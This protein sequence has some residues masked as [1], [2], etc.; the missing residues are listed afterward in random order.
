M[1]NAAVALLPLASTALT[2]NTEAP[3]VVGVPEI[4]PDA[5]RV[6]PAGNEPDVSFHA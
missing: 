2:V 6:S 5:E 1:L 3:A 4:E